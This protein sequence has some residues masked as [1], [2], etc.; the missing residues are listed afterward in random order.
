MNIVVV[1]AQYLL[2]DL[3]ADVGGD[4]V[5]DIAEGSAFLA[6]AGHCYKH[7]FIPLHQLD[8]VDGDGIVD[9]YR[10]HGAQS[11]IVHRFSDDGDIVVIFAGIY[12]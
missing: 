5:D 1:G 4:R 11:A 9:G 10:Y 6:A 8:I 12:S 7:T 3:F 2:F